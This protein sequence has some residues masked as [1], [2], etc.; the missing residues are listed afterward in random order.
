MGELFGKEFQIYAKTVAEALR[1]LEVNFSNFKQYFIEAH[2]RDVGFIIDV[3]ENNLDYEKELL[4]PFKEGDIIITPAP[5]GAKSAIAKILA[6]ILIVVVTWVTFGMGGAGFAWAELAGWQQFVILSAFSMATSLAMAGIQQMMA[7]D[8]ATDEDQEQSYLFNG[9]EQ[10]V[11]EGDPVPVLYGRL[12]VPGVP[13]SFEMVPGYSY[14][15]NAWLINGQT[16]NIGNI[17]G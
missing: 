7:P 6:A 11:I 4:M 1:C 14:S 12:R 13:M 3:G 17:T 8:P 9:A 2:E 16:L 5:A 10:N 15:R